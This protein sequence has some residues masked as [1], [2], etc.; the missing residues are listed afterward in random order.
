MSY[1]LENDQEVGYLYAVH[2]TSYK[3][4]LNNPKKLYR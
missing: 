3:A 2:N 1:C 4:V